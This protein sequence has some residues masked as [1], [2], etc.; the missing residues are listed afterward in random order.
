MKML[1]S[2]TCQ[3]ELTPCRL[4]LMS[5]GS[6]PW[7]RAVCLLFSNLFTRYRW[8]QIAQRLKDLMEGGGKETSHVLS[9]Y[10]KD[11]NGGQ[12]C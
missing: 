10:G 9:N 1:T 11:P 2:V 6:V 3:G 5:I 7:Y 4:V 12:V 8:S